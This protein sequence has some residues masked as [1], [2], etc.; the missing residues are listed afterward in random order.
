MR[1]MRRDR[2]RKGDRL[3]TNGDKGG[4]LSRRRNM[5]AG[6]EMTEPGLYITARR[7]FLNAVDEHVPEARKELQRLGDDPDRASVVQW[8]QRHGFRGEGYNGDWLG[9][10]ARQV[11]GSSLLSHGWPFMVVAGRA[12]DFPAFHDRWDP[13]RESAAAFMERVG[14]Y[15]QRQRALALESGFVDTTGKN[16]D[17]TADHFRWLALY[18]VGGLECRDI[19][20]MDAKAGRANP[21]LSAGIRAAADR[22]AK[23]IQATAKLTGVRLRPAKRGAPTKKPK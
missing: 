19:A 11:A 6:A 2:D 22:I 13:S 23:A 5:A 10:F 4:G 3:P 17:G 1:G 7:L 12:V 16:D 8:A 14:E 21:R 9:R 18:Q 15:V 20:A